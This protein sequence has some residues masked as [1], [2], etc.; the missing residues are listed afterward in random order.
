MKTEVQF[1]PCVSQRVRALLNNK[2]TP[3]WVRDSFDDAVRKAKEYKHPK[4]AQHPTA[5][6]VF[7]G[8]LEVLLTAAVWH[9]QDA[10]SEFLK[11]SLRELNGVD[12][13]IELCGRCGSLIVKR[14]FFPRAIVR[15]LIGRNKADLQKPIG[16]RGC[17]CD[18]MSRSTGG[19][20]PN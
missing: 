8:D 9:Y 15:K 13:D 10:L 1:D 16:S 11:R 4:E 12:P 3:R 19:T 14:V 6:L 2:S 17:G 18:C 7:M 5:L 20:K